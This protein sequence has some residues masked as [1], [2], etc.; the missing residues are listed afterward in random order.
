MT[1]FHFCF[2]LAHWGWIQADFYRD[3]VWTWQR[4]G[5]LS[6]FL[7]C[8][9]AGQQRA[10]ALGQAPGRFWRRWLQVAGAALLVSVGSWLVFPRS[11]IYFGVLHAVAVMLPLVRW[12]AGLGRW[13]WALGALAVASKFVA[14][15]VLALPAMVRVAAWFNQPGPNVL[16][17]ITA[18][19][20]TEDYVPLL[21]W[22]GVMWMGS[23]WVHGH[24]RPP[25]LGRVRGVLPMRAGRALVWLGRHSLSWYL[26]HQPVLIGAILGAS[27]VLT[28]K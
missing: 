28:P 5:I 13:A 8:A 7:L 12:G 24:A 4:T 26:L 16:G 25:G 2:D 18:L 3:P 22:L 23:A 17:W 19:P 14:A 6:L 27:L 20:V 11:W 10:A 9:G 21:P 15:A 1:V